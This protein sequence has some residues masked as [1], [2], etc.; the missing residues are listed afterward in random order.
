MKLDSGSV[1][2]FMGSYEK[3]DFDTASKTWDENPGRVKVAGCIA[4]A[5]LIEV[6]V[7][8]NMDA[9]DYGCGT[10][11]VT[12]AIQPHVR[13]ITCL[14]SS[15][16]MLDVLERKVKDEGITS[17]RT[18]L[19]DLEKDA[20]PDL[21]VDLLI[22]SMTM[23][24][25]SDLGR[26]ITAF[27]RMLKSGGYLAIADLDLD[28]G[29]FHEDN[30]GVVHFGFDRAELMNMLDVAGFEDVSARTACFFPKEVAGK[31]IR[32][33]SIFLITARKH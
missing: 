16:G 24:H 23:H 11:L 7:S 33:F 13:S 6:P 20:V 21:H 12:L 29:E 28:D 4:D 31:G 1:R 27:S 25:V 14:D 8:K 32:E 17:V 18:M 15:S 9:L 3:R 2:C 30:T 22:C 26:V 19:L 5:I 10:G